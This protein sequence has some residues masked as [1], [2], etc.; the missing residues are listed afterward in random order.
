MVESR[1]EVIWY[2]KLSFLLFGGTK[3]GEAYL[4]RKTFPEI[5]NLAKRQKSSRICGKRWG[6]ESQEEEEEAKKYLFH[7][8]PRFPFYSAKNE[9]KAEKCFLAFFS[10]PAHIWCKLHFL[11]EGKGKGVWMTRMAT[12]LKFPTI[13]FID[14]VPY[15][16]EKLSCFLPQNKGKGKSLK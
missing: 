13:H 14:N 4:A 1:T 5:Q 9:A 6:Y 8:S 7:F 11:R 15:N 10:L 2:K 16:S 3:E 12:A